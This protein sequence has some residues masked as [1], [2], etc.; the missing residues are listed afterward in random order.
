MDTSSPDG[1]CWSGLEAILWFQQQLT[2]PVRIRSVLKKE[3]VCGGRA[4]GWQL[5]VGERRTRLP[6]GLRDKEGGC[7]QRAPSEEEEIL[8]TNKKRWKGMKYWRVRAR[9]TR[10]T[11]QT[12]YE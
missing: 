3:S 7:N 2:N 9:K 1:P 10:L 4:G 8:N 5:S 6:E 12:L 11:S